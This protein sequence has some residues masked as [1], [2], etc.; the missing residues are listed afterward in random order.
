MTSEPVV[1]ILI[2]AI[3]HVGIGWLAFH[4][5][6]LVMHLKRQGA[7][8]CSRSVQGTFNGVRT[9]TGGMTTKSTPRRVRRPG[10]A[11]ATASRN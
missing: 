4:A 8:S 9:E 6:H 7:R 2:R 1:R 10:L 5:T 3:Y 11:A